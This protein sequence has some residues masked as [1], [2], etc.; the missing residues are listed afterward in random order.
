MSDPYLL[1]AF[2]LD[3]LDRVELHHLTVVPVEELPRTLLYRSRIGQT[4][5]ARAVGYHLGLPS[6]GW[7]VLYAP[8]AVTLVGGDEAYVAR[9]RGAWPKAEQ[10]VEDFADRLDFWRITVL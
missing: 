5:V 4:A 2:S 7:R 1:H 6:D 8:G 9:F 10:P 3:M